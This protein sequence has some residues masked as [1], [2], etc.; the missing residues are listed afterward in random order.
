MRRFF[1]R[2]PSPAMAVGF[3]A[4]VAAL[5]GTAVALPGVNLVDSGDIKNGQVKRKDIAKNAVNGAKVANGALSGADVKDGSLTPSDFSGS[6]Q[7]PKGD[8]GDK[9]ETGPPGPSLVGGAKSDSGT[10]G[11]IAGTMVDLASGATTTGQ[12]VLPWTG[13]I[14]ANGFADVDTSAAATSRTR[15]NLFISDGTGPN[16]GLTTFSPNSFGDTPA[17]ANYHISIPLTGFVIKPAGTY[18]IAVR[19]AVVSGSVVSYSAALSYTAV[20]AS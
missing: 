19:C 16:N 10:I 17:V 13:L 3:I 20:P 11:P 1:T 5:S 15:C 14:T 4:L 18:N 9:G 12:V 6:V 2:R 8:K 7:G